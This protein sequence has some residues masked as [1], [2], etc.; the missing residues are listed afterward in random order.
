MDEVPEEGD[1]QCAAE[2]ATRFV[3]MDLTLVKTG[4]RLR[5][6]RAVAPLYLRKHRGS[7]CQ[8]GEDRRP[9]EKEVID[10]HPLSPN[11]STGFSS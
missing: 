7:S 4:A 11:N 2:K 3:K 9:D 10:T 5:A 1:S 6:A 8:N